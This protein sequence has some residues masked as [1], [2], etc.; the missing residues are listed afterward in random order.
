MSQCRI[1]DTNFVFD[2]ATTLTASSASGEFPVS[3]LKKYHRYNAWRTTGVTSET[4]VIDLQ[5]A[6]SIDAFAMV[7]DP[8]E[9]IKFTSSATIKIQA[10]ATNT[11]G[12]PAVDVTLS[13][14]DDFSVITYFWTT[15]Q[16]YR[17]W[18]L[19]MADAT[20]PYGYLEIPK[21]ILSTSTQLTQMPNVG[22]VQL[23]ADSSKVVETDY[24]HRYADNYPTLRTLE[25]EYIEIPEADKLTLSAI[26]RRLGK[27]TPLA[28]SLDPLQAHFSNKDEHFLYGY[29]SNDL[30][31]SQVFTTYFDV[32]LGVVEAL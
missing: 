31:I 32:K 25:L 21:I 1:M 28:I 29:I 14:D 27:V 26:Y 18:R 8:N 3:N 2:S 7:F 20:N 23:V 9:G 30:E 10:N 22:F 24:G 6:E 11:W 17:Y 12:S 5:T 19:S 4:L 15:G 16:S 13:I